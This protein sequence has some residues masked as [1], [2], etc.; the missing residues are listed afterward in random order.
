MKVLPKTGVLKNPNNWKGTILLDAISKISSIFVNIKLKILLNTRE[1]THQI[2]AT[3]NLGFQDAVFVL[4]RS[5]NND[6]KN[7]STSGWCLSI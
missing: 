3:P 1:I 2:G 4:K 7:F 5:F 6:V